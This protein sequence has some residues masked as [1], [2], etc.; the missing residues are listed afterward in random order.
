M[1]KLRSMECDV[2]IYDETTTGERRIVCR[3]SEENGNCPKDSNRYVFDLN[4]IKE[5]MK[6]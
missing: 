6:I 5:V 2:E 3:V 4:C 1:L